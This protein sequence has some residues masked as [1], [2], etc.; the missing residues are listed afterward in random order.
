[1]SFFKFRGDL[2]VGYEWP[3]KV[4][5]DQE[6]RARFNDSK[7]SCSYLYGRCYE[8]S[9]MYQNNPNIMDRIPLNDI[10]QQNDSD[11]MVRSRSLKSSK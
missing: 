5:S 8:I 4:P 7:K 3:I 2:N 11:I 6:L 1:M 9:P 10:I